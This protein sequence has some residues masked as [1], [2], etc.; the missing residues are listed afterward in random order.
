MSR[1]EDRA[2]D[3]RSRAEAVMSKSKEKEA[4]RLSSREKE[5]QAEALKTSRLRAL[6]L[7]KETADKKTQTQAGV[8]RKK[9]P[10]CR[11]KT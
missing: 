10:G 6:R 7:A 11:P 9:A 2:A 1:A 3:A 8:A 4:D 5:K